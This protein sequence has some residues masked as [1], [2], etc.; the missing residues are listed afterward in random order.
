MKNNNIRKLPAYPVFVKDPFFSLWSNTDNP[1]ESNPT[2]WFGR[3]VAMA[4]YVIIGSEKNRFIGQGQGRALTL[5]NV[6][7]TALKTIYTFSCEK[8]DMR[9]EFCSPLPLDNLDVLSFP[10]CYASYAVTPKT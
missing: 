9:V 7:V 8:F 4:G 5:T 2:F 3:E 10:L 6:D 1:A